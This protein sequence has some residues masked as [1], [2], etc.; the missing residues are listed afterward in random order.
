[1]SN[2]KN[3]VVN[4]IYLNI[5]AAITTIVSLFATRVIL[6]VLGA[7]DFGVYGTVS[8]S[9]AMLALLNSALTLATQRYLNFA[10]GQN[11]TVKQKQI[12]NN[13][14]LLHIAL[15][16]L[17]VLTMES[18]YFPLFNGILTIPENR[19]EVAKLLYH[20]MCVSTFFTII[21]V[22][23][24]ALINA[25][26]NF[27]YYSVVGIIESLLKLFTALMLLWVTLDKLFIYGLSLVLISMGMMFIMYI[28]CKK[29]YI[30]SEISLCQYYNKSVLIELSKFAGWRFIGVFSQFFGNHGSNILMNHFFGTIVIAAKNIGDQVGGQLY[31]VS[32]NMMRAF[33]PVI[34]KAESQGDTNYMLQLSMQACRFGYLLYLAIAVPFVFAMPQILELWLK[35]VPEWAILFCQLQ[36]LRMLLEQLSSPLYT[37]LSAKGDITMASIYDFIVG[38]I[39]FF[40]LWICYEKGSSPEYHYYISILLMVIVSSFTKIWLCR[41]ICGLK[42]AIFCKEVLGP[43]IL[44]SIILYFSCAFICNIGTPFFS[45]LLNCFF[46]ALFVIL[47]GLKNTEKKLILKKT[48]SPKC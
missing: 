48:K 38:V 29:K 35:D 4:T 22:P 27:L 43:C 6:N 44:T 32:S 24:D 34:V 26:E 45:F 18:L 19:V 31:V 12:F 15:G 16:I 11:D 28:Y 33:N 3:I 40:M 9:V 36:I 13:S 37:S 1:M 8:G 39:T 23:Y 5:K 25:H 46:S 21:T 20:F 10:L 2:K 17:I 7:S 30:E 14:I 47:F 42:I 41:K